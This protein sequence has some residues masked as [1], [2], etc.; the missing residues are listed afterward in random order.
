MDDR[1][2]ERRAMGA[3]QLMTAKITEFAAH[4]TAGD[5]SAAERA[6]T[7]AIGALEVHLDQTDQLITQTF[8]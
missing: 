5:R 4:L 8:A 1:T 6:R 3:E 2:L 7:E